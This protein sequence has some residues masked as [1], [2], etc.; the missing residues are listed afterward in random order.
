MKRVS[1]VAALWLSI[2]TPSQAQVLDNPRGEAREAD[3][4][5]RANEHDPETP[6]ADPNDVATPASL[7]KAMYETLSGRASETRNWNRFRSLM[8]PD[9]RFV[10]ES[11]ASD[12]TVRR[13]SLSLEE[14]IKSNA[15]SFAAQGFFE[16]GGIS[17]EEI[18][19]HLAVV[20]TP[21]QSRR[22]PN[23][24]P[25]ARGIKHV[26]LTSDGKRW[27]IESIL[28]E[29]EIPGSPLPPEAETALKMRFGGAGHEAG[30]NDFVL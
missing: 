23:E 10:T 17:H 29:R 15:N 24:A 11:L 27:F 28:W 30:L 3:R 13:R 25:F 20:I 2:A 12:G 8:T 14:L 7:V 18:W 1:V 19:G 16:D 21:Y 6:P 9:A 26:E 4:T 22:A 5:A